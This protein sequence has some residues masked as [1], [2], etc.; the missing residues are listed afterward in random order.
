M[1]KLSKE[2]IAE[3]G[4]ALVVVLSF[5]L[6]A[7]FLTAPFFLTAKLR[8]LKAKARYDHAQERLLLIS[9]AKSSMALFREQKIPF[10]LPI[11]AQ[12]RRENSILYLVAID[13]SGLVDLNAAQSDLLKLGLFALGFQ[14]DSVEILARSI[15]AYRSIER[16][17]ELASAK[18]SKPL[19]GLK[20]G[21]FDH[22]AELY[23][24]ADFLGIPLWKISQVFTVSNKRGTVVTE[25]AV[26]KLQQILTSVSR[27]EFPSVLQTGVPVGSRSIVIVYQNGDTEQSAV[28]SREQMIDY[29]G[30][31]VVRV[32][33]VTTFERDVSSIEK[34]SIN[35][36]TRC[37]KILGFNPLN[38]IRE[39]S[40]YE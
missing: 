34:M 15:V 4:Y 27:A 20:N 16:L 14:G 29:D 17:G 2:T 19:A 24:F 3:D 13:Q 12:C 11:E 40:L 7:S 21:P 25:S 36:V 37:E 22:V 18:L 33:N 9:L 39:S 30:V 26:G 28:H 35:G 32:E 8:L 6:I 1:T 38:V 31:G 23:E 5:L 10:Q